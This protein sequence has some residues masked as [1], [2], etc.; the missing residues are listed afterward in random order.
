MQHNLNLVWEVFAML[1]QYLRR[2]GGS[3]SSSPSGINIACRLVI[4]CLFAR[5]SLQ[6]NHFYTVSTREIF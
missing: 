2:G 4:F 6:E 5:M 3:L 1:I